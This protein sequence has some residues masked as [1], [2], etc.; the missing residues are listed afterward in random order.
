VALRCPH[1]R[2]A[3]VPPARQSHWQA[4][5]LYGEINGTV[6]YHDIS[7]LCTNTVRA[8]LIL[9][10]VKIFKKHFEIVLEFAQGDK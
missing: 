4:V 8:H 1:T 9:L 7:T 3:H 10:N 6:I 2:Q 5:L